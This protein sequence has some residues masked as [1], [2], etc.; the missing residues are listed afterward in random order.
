MNSYN[1]LPIPAIFFYNCLQ[2]LANSLQ[3]DVQVSILRILANSLKFLQ[4][5]KLL[6]FLRILSP[7]YKDLQANTNS[8]KAIQFLFKLL[9]CLTNVLQFLINSCKSCEFLQILK[10]SY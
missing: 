9:K 2:I 8:Y 10:M 3:F 7:S 6:Q 5:L 1:Y 4:I